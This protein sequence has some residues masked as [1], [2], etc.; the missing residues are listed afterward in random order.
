MF[1]LN[2]VW[3]KIP[4]NLSKQ[5]NMWHSG[6]DLWTPG[7]LT[8]AHSRWTTPLLL[9]GDPSRSPSNPR[10]GEG[11]TSCW[12]WGWPVSRF[13]VPG[14]GPSPWSMQKSVE[15]PWKLFCKSLICSAC[16]RGSSVKGTNPFKKKECACFAKLHTWEYFPLLQFQVP[17]TPHCQMGELPSP[18]K[19]L[20]T[21]SCQNSASSPLPYC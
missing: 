16:L 8:D 10:L 11:R 13:C 1:V 14:P 17:F 4:S 6:I 15:L 18:F 19:R 20:A 12:V 9:R 21:E 3:R 7:S 5:M 2:V